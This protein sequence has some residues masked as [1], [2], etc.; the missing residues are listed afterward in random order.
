MIDALVEALLGAGYVVVGVSITLAGMRL[1][2]WVMQ[3]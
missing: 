2:N 1:H 3:R